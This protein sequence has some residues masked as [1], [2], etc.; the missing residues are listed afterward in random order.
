LSA[1]YAAVAA[2]PTPSPKAAPKSGPAATTT[3]GPTEVTEALGEIPASLAGT[4][5]TVINGKL[6]DR[7]MSG[8]YAFRITH[9][10]AAWQVTELHG[11][12][13]P[14]LKTELDAANAQG[15]VYTPSA[16][17]LATIKDLLPTLKQPAPAGRALNITLRDP[18]HFIKG[19]EPDPRQQTAKL[20]LELVSKNKNNVVASARVFFIQD[21]T[22]DRLA[23]DVSTLN[24]AAAYGGTLV[25]IN[26]EGPFTMFRIK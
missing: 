8:W 3:S 20:T 21:I 4:W 25:P 9:D 12:S 23:G 16:A 2:P 24:L 14:Q 19:T 10:G 15:T 26:V 22:A 1:P 18:A 17:A 7:Y 6:N 5:F 11:E 13:T